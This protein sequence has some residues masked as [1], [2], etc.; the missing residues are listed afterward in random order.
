MSCC[1]IIGNRP[2]DGHR[3]HRQTDQGKTV[4]VTE[5]GKET[6]KMGC[7][8]ISIIVPVYRAEDYLRRCV[9][10][11]TGQ[12]YQNTE[13][14]LVDDGS[15]DGCPLL[16]DQYAGSDERIRVIHKENGGLVSAWQAGVKASTGDYLCFVDSDDWV[17]ADMLSG[18]VP[19]LSYKKRE[20][21]CCNFVINRPDRITEH[22]H[23]QKPGI[24]EN[25]ELEEIKNNL[26]GNENR[27]ISM[28]RCMKLFSRALITDNMKYCNPQITM[29]ED[30][31]ITLPALLDCERL[32]VMEG[33]L[34]Y[35]Y[36]Y[37]AQSMVHQYDASL[38]EGVHTLYLTIQEVFR[39]KDRKN[40]EVQSAKEYVYLLF[41]VVKNEI[42]GGG[43]GSKK[44]DGYKKIREICR[45]EDNRKIIEKYP[46][47][48]NEKANRLLYFVVKHPWRIV[49]LLLRTVFRLHDNF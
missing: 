40:G 33:A 18:M 32:V 16:C 38:Y 25:G 8:K 41:L 47:T 10:S 27:T 5:S 36:F 6:G 42:R 9:D 11:L 48:V 26:L 45:G 19:F 3:T 22:Y 2:T 12:S 46:V 1:V 20:I 24:Y 34:Y 35:H 14:V 17:E 49:L 29:G 23:G 28:S 4:Q 44:A 43:P 7:G 30:V 31:N 39:Q 13:L 15:P 37:H 21:I